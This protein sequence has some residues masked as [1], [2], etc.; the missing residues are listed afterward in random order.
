MY[1]YGSVINK[2]KN[3]INEMDKQDYFVAIYSLIWIVLILIFGIF[4]VLGD[5]PRSEGPWASMHL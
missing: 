3:L 5:A 2:S 1:G 4:F